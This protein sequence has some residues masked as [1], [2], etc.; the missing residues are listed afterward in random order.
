MVVGIDQASELAEFIIVT[1]SAPIGEELCKAA[2]VL[3]CYR[4]IDSP[5]RGFQVGFTVGLGFA[6]LENILYITG[7]FTE[8]FATFA[9]VAFLRGIGSIPGHAVWTGL[10]GLGIGWLLSRRPSLGGLLPEKSKGIDADFVLIDSKTGQMV[11]DAT[12]A[13]NQPAFGNLRLWNTQGYLNPSMPDVQKSVWRLPTTAW[14]GIGLA[15]L[16]HAFWNGS[17]TLVVLLV[18]NLAGEVAA[19]LA[20]LG[21][22]LMMI[23]ILLWAA[24]NIMRSLHS[25]PSFVDKDFN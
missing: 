4:Y 13:A 9:V 19:I 6:M 21:W 10:S 24:R 14:T 15:I 25:V 16:G 23:G 11:H 3:C 1:I 5:R 20:M 7:S 22:T 8:G 12:G 17:T 18:D 2:A